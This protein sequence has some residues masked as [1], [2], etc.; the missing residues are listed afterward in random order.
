VQTKVV[1]VVQQGN[2]SADA[3]AKLD[4]QLRR[5]AGLETA[6]ERIRP[7]AKKEV[8]MARNARGELVPTAF[9]GP[10]EQKVFNRPP[11]W[12]TMGTGLRPA[13][14]GGSRSEINAPRPPKFDPPPRTSDGN[15]AP[16]MAAMKNTR[17][18]GIKRTE[19]Y[20]ATRYTTRTVP[21]YKYATKTYRPPDTND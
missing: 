7:G 16:Y 19:E 14:V 5:T 12:V 6:P 2:V 3:M 21:R 8:P 10:A 18:V 11:G 15:I 20:P 9:A 13:S 1:K 4:L 17:A